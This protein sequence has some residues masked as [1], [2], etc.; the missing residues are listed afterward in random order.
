MGCTSHTSHIPLEFTNEQLVKSKHATT[1]SARPVIY[2][3]EIAGLEIDQQKR[4]SLEVIPGVRRS[5]IM[6]DARAFSTFPPSFIDILDTPKIISRRQ[7]T[8]AE[9]PRG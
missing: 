9:S 1:E 7:I 6:E 3:N 2:K 8:S 5:W 4:S